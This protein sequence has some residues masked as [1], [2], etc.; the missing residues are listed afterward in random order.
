M[1]RAKLQGPGVKHNTKFIPLKGV[2][3]DHRN[4]FLRII[5]SLSQ[6]WGGGSLTT[7][8]LSRPVIQPIGVSGV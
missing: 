4:L 3:S 8:E 7:T 1:S 2:G 6:V 5:T